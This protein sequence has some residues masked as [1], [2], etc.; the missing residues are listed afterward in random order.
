MNWVWNLHGNRCERNRHWVKSGRLTWCDYK[1]FD[2]TNP[3]HVLQLEKQTHECRNR[4][5]SPRKDLAHRCTCGF[6][7]KMQVLEHRI[8]EQLGV[9]KRN[10]LLLSTKSVWMMPYSSIINTNRYKLR[11]ECTGENTWD[12]GLHKHV[13]LIWKYNPWTN[14][15]LHKSKY[16]L[17]KIFCEN[18][19][20]L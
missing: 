4:G 12:T 13:T 8:L 1:T 14:E 9:T 20:S 19:I 2:K 10:H 7:T 6:L 17:S 16:N 5:E 18:E 11:R 3:R 15:R